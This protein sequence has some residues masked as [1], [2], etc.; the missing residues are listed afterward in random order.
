VS[1]EADGFWTRVD[2]CLDAREDPFT[3]PAIVEALVAHPER[4]LALQSM[5]RALEDVRRLPADSGPPPR[6]SV[7]SL[8]RRGVA[9][10]V[11]LGVVGL[12]YFATRRVPIVPPP[13]RAR[14]VVNAFVS[15]AM[16]VASWTVSVLRREGE[17]FT[18]DSIGSNGAASSDLGASRRDSDFARVTFG[19]S[20]RLP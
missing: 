4:T 12:G 5:L 9:A 8:M 17:A 3:D 15:D 16:P 18:Q 2:E 6:R 11:I 20:T 14:A 19:R 1:A 10:A 7:P 13:S